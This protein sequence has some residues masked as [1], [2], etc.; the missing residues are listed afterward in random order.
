MFDCTVD[1]SNAEIE[2]FQSLA[3]NANMCCRLKQICSSVWTSLYFFKLF[4]KWVI[5]C[6]FSLFS[7]FQLT[8]N[9]QN[10]ILPVTGFEPLQSEAT[11]LPTV[12]QPLWAVKN[13]IDIKNHFPHQSSAAI[14]FLSR[15]KVSAANLTQKNQSYDRHIDDDD[16]WRRQLRV[17]LWKRNNYDRY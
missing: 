4:Q 11:A 2:N 12:P 17:K 14:T 6:L 1:Y 10:N 16:G 13:I 8:V 15:C 9:V 5:P 7:S 3:R